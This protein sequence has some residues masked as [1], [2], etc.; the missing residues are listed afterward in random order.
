MTICGCANTSLRENLSEGFQTVRDSK[1]PA[2]LQR[3]AKMMKWD[4][5][6]GLDI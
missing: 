5:Q 4:H 1:Q 3:L 6:A 2:Q